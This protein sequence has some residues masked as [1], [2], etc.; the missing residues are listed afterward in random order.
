MEF[1]NDPV[2]SISD[3]AHYIKKDQKNYQYYYEGFQESLYGLKPNL[4]CSE[5][6]DL[7]TTKLQCKRGVFEEKNSYNTLPKP[8]LLRFFQVILVTHLNMRKV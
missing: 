6:R 8:R 7:I 4:S 2:S 3:D 5:M 1:L